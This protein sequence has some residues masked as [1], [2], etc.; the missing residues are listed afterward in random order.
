MHSLQPKK[1]V[2]GLSNNI[3]SLVGLLSGSS[4][5]FNART[6]YQQSVAL[7]VDTRL[8]RGGYTVSGGT[9]GRSD[10]VVSVGL[11]GLDCRE[12]EMEVV[13]GLG[14]LEMDSD[15]PTPQIAATEG[16]PIGTT[17]SLC[18]FLLVAPEGLAPRLRF[19]CAA[20]A[21]LTACAAGAPLTKK[22]VL[23]CR[24]PW[25]PESCGPGG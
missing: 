15:G 6:K 11:S 2:D 3:G 22:G 12:A 23:S 16:G 13:E 8:F 4:L 25:F 17:M 14:A 1:G 18:R 24:A 10:S 19:A 20:G 9:V 7:A 21:P 5:S